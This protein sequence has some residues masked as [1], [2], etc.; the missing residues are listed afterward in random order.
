MFSGNFKSIADL[1]LT[2]STENKCIEF[3]EKQRWDG[4]V[5]SPFDAK[6]KVWKCKNN[7]YRCVNTGKYFNVKTGTLFDNTKIPLQKWFIAIWLLT[8]HKKGTSSIQLA[9]DL[10]I[11]QKSAWFLAQRIRNCFCLPQEEMM[12]GV[13]EVDE[14]FVGGKNINRHKNKKI[15]YSQGRSYKD[16]TPVFGMLQRGG[17]LAAYVVD[18]TSKSSLQPIILKNLKRFSYLISDEWSGYNGLSRHYFHDIVRHQCKEYVKWDNPL[19]HTNTIEGFWGIFKRGVKGIYN[20][21]SRK[22]LQKYVDEFVFRYNSRKI[23]ESERFCLFLCNICHR[24]KYTD[25]IATS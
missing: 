5:A 21:L 13:V 3:L 22:H 10:G 17:R 19:T 7:R 9:K 15:K 6:S 11:T 1:I 4:N 8:S 14:T 23:K 2:F 12:D 18:D 24:L 16:K 20:S 25:L